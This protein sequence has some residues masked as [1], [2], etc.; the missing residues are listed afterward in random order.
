MK[1]LGFS[2]SITGELLH[3]LD[4]GWQRSRLAHH[5]KRVVKITSL[6]S[7]VRTV[8]GDGFKGQLSHPN[9]NK[10]A[11]AAFTQ[12]FQ[13]ATE[14]GS[15]SGSGLTEPGIAPRDAL[16][17]AWGPTDRLASTDRL[18]CIALA[19]TARLGVQARTLGLWFSL[20]TLSNPITEQ[21]SLLF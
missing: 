5:T 3:F 15:S 13:R 11:R 4:L 6:N 20:R 7:R 18:A 16:G 17:A 19:P 2:S 21:L 14:G 9:T 12:A 8:L 10:L 1:G